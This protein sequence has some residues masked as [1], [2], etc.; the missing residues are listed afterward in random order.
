MCYAVGIYVYMLTLNN[1]NEQLIGWQGSVLFFSGPLTFDIYVY[2]AVYFIKSVTFIDMNHLCINK[3][4]I[5]Y[6]HLNTWFHYD[7]LCI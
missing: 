4:S 7:Y 3:Y 6:K 1:S 5:R 2:V